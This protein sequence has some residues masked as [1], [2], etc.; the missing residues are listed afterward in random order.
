MT[1]YDRSGQVAVPIAIETLGMRVP[2]VLAAFR[3]GNWGRL[4]AW[5]T[6]KGGKNMMS[7]EKNPAWPSPAQRAR[8]TSIDI[9]MEK[10]SNDQNDI[11]V[12]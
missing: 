2:C 4:G 6:S 8:G 12:I 1:N 10:R 3:I 5:V 11:G 9:T 7:T